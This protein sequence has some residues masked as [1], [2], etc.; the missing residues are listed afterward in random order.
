VLHVPQLENKNGPGDEY[1]GWKKYLYRYFIWMPRCAWTIQINSRVC[2]ADCSRAHP[3]ADGK[4]LHS[5]DANLKRKPDHLQEHG[6]CWQGGRDESQPSCFGNY[7]DTTA[8]KPLITL[9]A[10]AMTL[11]FQP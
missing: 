9:N 4:E 11:P 5:G 3:S 1:A 6:E 10:P 7:S 2:V 8:L